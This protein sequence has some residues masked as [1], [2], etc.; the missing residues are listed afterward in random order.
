MQPGK[1]YSCFKYLENIMKVVKWEEVKDE[2]FKYNGEDPNWFKVYIENPYTALGS[3]WKFSYCILAARYKDYIDSIFK[4]EARKDDV[5]ICSFP[6][7]GT[8]WYWSVLLFK[9]IF[10]STKWDSFRAQE[11]VWLV[12]SG[13]NFK[14]AKEKLLFQRSPTLRQM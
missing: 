3:S 6:K 7:S 2:R 11:M 10:Q 12:Q 14:E 8:T 9:S 4:Y 1:T 5:W 13:F